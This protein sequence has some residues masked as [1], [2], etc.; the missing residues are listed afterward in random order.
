MIG[1]RSIELE[2]DGCITIE[3]AREGIEAGSNVLVAGSAIFGKENYS[4]SISRLR[5]C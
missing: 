5:S 1:D 2:V 4:K 3:N